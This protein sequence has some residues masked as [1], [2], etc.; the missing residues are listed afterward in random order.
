MILE[1]QYI[2]SLSAKII[3]VQVGPDRRKIYLK[4]PLT[5]TDIEFLQTHQCLFY[6]LEKEIQFPDQ[7]TGEIVV[8]KKTTLNN[9]KPAC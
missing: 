9:F 3:L 1:G 8:W 4:R 2:K 5:I 6:V 7:K